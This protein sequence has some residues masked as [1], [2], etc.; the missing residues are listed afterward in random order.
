MSPHDASIFTRLSLS[1]HRD[2]NSHR[3]DGVPALLARV[4]DRRLCCRSHRRGHHPG[5]ASDRIRIGRLADACIGASHAAMKD[6]TS[7]YHRPYA[8]LAVAMVNSTVCC[9]SLKA[10]LTIS[11]Y[12][13]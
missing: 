1:D 2:H 11:P 3:N 13:S 8:G 12:I 9:Y 4:A 5:V 10:A 7:S 6:T